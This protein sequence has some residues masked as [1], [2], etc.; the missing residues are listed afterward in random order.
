MTSTRIP[1]PADHSNLLQ[2][3]EVVWEDYYTKEFYSI[4]PF[5]YDVAFLHGLDVFKPW[6]HEDS[7]IPL[8]IREWGDIKEVLQQHFSLRDL[9]NTSPL[10]RKGI[11]YFYEC[12]YWCNEQPVVAITCDFVDLGVKPVNLSERI[13]YILSRPAKYQS[14]V[15]LAELFI[16]MEKLFRKKQIMKK[17]SKQ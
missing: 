3:N 14:F 4:T 8:V 2:Q 17:A 9:S 6:N 13:N 1:L 16:E 5:L 15:Q 11:S 10:M 7:T 12:L